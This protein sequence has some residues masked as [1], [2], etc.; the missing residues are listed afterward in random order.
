MGSKRWQYGQAKT[1]WQGKGDYWQLQS[2][3]ATERLKA[4]NMV[5]SGNSETVMMTPWI[6]RDRAMS[7]SKL[8]LG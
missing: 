4:Q 1:G 5:D 3:N 7:D 8:K 6:G 2:G